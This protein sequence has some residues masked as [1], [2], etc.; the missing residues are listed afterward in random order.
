MPPPVS[1]ADVIKTYP[2]EAAKKSLQLRQLILDTA[3]DIEGVGQITE[4]FKWG[5]PA[6]LT[7]ASGSGSTIRLAWKL[8]TPDVLLVLFNCKTTLVDAYRT[9][10]PHLAFEG[11]RA[12][13]LE[14]GD[15]LPMD[16]LRQCFALALT[17]HQNKVKPAKRRGRTAAA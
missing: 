1:P 5:E 9:L 2:P 6:Y 17:Y 15:K 14:V 13:V 7:E 11:N 16:E 8:K 12:S 3:R 10:F 4:T